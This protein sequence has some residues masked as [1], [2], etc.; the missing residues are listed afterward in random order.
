M[1]VYIH[2]YALFVAA[3]DLADQTLVLFDQLHNLVVINY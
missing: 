1:R 2:I 3:C